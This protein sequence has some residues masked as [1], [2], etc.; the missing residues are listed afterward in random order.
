MRRILT[1]VLILTTVMSYAQTGMVK[2]VVLHEETSLPYAEVS[3]TLPTA[4][5]ISSTNDKGEYSFS[6]LPYG[7]Y[8]MIVSPDGILEEH[9]SITVNA[10][11]NNVEAIK[12]K[13]TDGTTLNGMDNSVANIE[14]ASS[15]DDNTVSSS[16]Q[17]VSSVLNASRDPFQ[18][19]ATF[20]WGQY[21]FRIRGYENDAN[22]LYLNGVPMNDLE[23]GGVFYN[24]WSGLNDV[25]RGRSVT[26]GLAPNDYNF[27]GTGM[28]TSLD[29]SAS[30]QRKGT[31][32]TYTATN[33]SYRN[34]IMLTHSSGLMKSG[35]AYSFSLSRRWAQEGQ[36]KGTFYDAY[37]YFGALEK[38]W[39]K[40]GVS[41]MVVGAPVKRGKVGP[42]TD[43]MFDLAGSHY[44][45]PNW[46]YQN[47]KVRNSR[48][49]KSNQPL[50][51]L[52]Y[53]AELSNK[54]KLTSAISYQVGET[55]QTAFDWNNAADPRPI[56]YRYMPSYYEDESVKNELIAKYKANPDMMQVQWDDLYQV[57]YNNN[58]NGNG[59]A[60]YLL[61]AI[62]EKSKKLNGAVNLSSVLNDH[63][64][65]YS[66]LN[67]QKQNNHN[68]ARVE[69]LLGA[70][71]TENV[72][73]FQS[74]LNGVVPTATQLNTLE[75]NK[76]LY[77][78]DDFD[79]NYNIHFSKAEW[80]LQSVFSYSK[81][82]FFVATELGYTG[83]YR[84][85]NYQSGIYLN[86]SYGKSSTNNFFTYKAKGG[87][88]YKLNGRNYLYANGMI[89]TRA[90]FVDNIIISPRTRNEMIS[91]PS[92]EKIQSAEVGYLL[93]SPFIKA[94]F[95]L[96]ATD[97]KNST[98]IKRYF[99]DDDRSFN[100]LV[101]QGI[102][103]RFTGIEAGTEIKVS[104]SLTLSLAAAFTQAFYTNRPYVDMY[105]DNELGAI[106][107]NSTAKGE[108]DTVY[109][110]DYYVPSGP[111]TALQASLN[112]RSKSFWFATLS[113]NY[114]ARNYMDFAPT[115]RTKEG[116]SGLAYESAEWHQ[117]I[118]QKKL[119]NAFTVDFNGGKSFKV[120][121]YI[122]KASNQM[123]LLLN[124]GVSNILNNQ[125]IKQY[126]FENLRV[127]NLNPEWFPAKYAYAMGTIYFINLSLRF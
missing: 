113:A 92:V 96:F 23:E 52:S 27:G 18:S 86:N 38:R 60:V 29:A 33:R 37:G 55:S 84:T 61:G 4:K 114:L 108:R 78:G 77:V 121:K 50:F 53:D 24:S 71:Y 70:N 25:F 31:K 19:A 54:T 14:N 28:N 73:L 125:N 67:F 122:K 22:V 74:S 56:Y 59:S 47:G 105:S 120:N 97:V 62:V 79:H 116:V 41:L 2:G 83:F 101:M 34:R 117:I 66:G 45:N 26:L 49:F 13:S 75:P 43:E 94:R 57:N 12:I 68:F 124:V 39:K 90:P 118:D 5:M 87:I 36:I 115:A 16:G 126:G 21:F 127:N 20:G 88:T 106:G 119:P 123:F 11:M 9:V 40:Q 58:R 32:L 6:N 85:G 51:V 15:E 103:R 107:N 8:E 80:F 100:S 93:R 104:P 64:T 44:Y 81:F 91:N 76:K 63:I 112:Y 1:V 111:Q 69:D 98:D 46:G 110:K 7:T 109:I 30:N 17:N 10:A 95:T 35:W 42:A 3:V 89:G 82:D 99:S 65:L 48:V 102:N 72:N